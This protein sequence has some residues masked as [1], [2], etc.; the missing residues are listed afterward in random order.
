MKDYVYLEVRAKLGHG[1]LIKRPAE[2]KRTLYF[3]CKLFLKQAVHV[4]VE[5]A[6]V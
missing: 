6:R 3:I 2:Y 4:R 1:K 5:T